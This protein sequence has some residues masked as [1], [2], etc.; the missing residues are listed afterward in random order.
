MKNK[1][2]YLGIIIDQNLGI[3]SQIQNTKM[4]IRKIGFQLWPIIRHKNMQTNRNLFQIYC[5][6]LINNIYSIG[7]IIK[8][9]EKQMIKQ[10]L[11]SEIKRFLMIPQSTPNCVIYRLIGDPE[12][13]IKETVIRTNEKEIMF[14]A[15]NQYRA[16]DTQR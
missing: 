5:L 7:E 3:K 16:Y 15:G 1:I 8:N 12:K 11:R 4:K 6:P 2:K 10:L 13:I 14:Q 9:Q